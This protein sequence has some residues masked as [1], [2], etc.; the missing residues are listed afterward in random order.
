MRYG[1]RGVFG[2]HGGLL[3]CGSAYQTNDQKQPKQIR[4]HAMQICNFVTAS[5]GLPLLL[6]EQGGRV[7][8]EVTVRGPWV[9]NSL[10]CALLVTPP[11][12]YKPACV[13]MIMYVI[14]VACSCSFVWSLVNTVGGHHSLV[15]PTVP[16]R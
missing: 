8:H 6:T 1:N 12:K 3:E 15:I 16:P 4:E 10:H 13:L 2:A 14:M 7:G 5:A 9:Y 11:K